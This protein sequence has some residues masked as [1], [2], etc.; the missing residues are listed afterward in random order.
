[1][2]KYYIGK[3]IYLIKRYPLQAKLI[4]IGFRYCVFS[5]ILI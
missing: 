3:L 4:N 2:S 1:M 5:Y